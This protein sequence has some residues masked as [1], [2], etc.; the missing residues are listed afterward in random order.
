LGGVYRELADFWE[1]S[2]VP[3]FCAQAYRSIGLAPGLAISRGR[4]IRLCVAKLR[5]KN[6]FTFSKAHS[7]TCRSGLLFFGGAINIV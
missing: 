1:T 7:F 6:Q 2:T 4:R 5:I 3:G